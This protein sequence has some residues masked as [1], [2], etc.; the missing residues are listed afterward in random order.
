MR[1][2]A[3][4]KYVAKNWLRSS[5]KALRQL[6]DHVP[7][8]LQ[9]FSQVS[10]QLLV[11][12]T[13]DIQAK[14][15]TSETI[16][17]EAYQTYLGLQFHRYRPWHFCKFPSEIDCLSLISWGDPVEK[18]EPWQSKSPGTPDNTDTALCRQKSQKAKRE[19]DNVISGRPSLLQCFLGMLN[20][21]ENHFS[22]G[23]VK[24]NMAGWVPKFENWPL[25]VCY[26]FFDIH[27][28]SSSVV[29][30]QD[31]GTLKIVCQIRQKWNTDGWF[32]ECG[33]QE[34]GLSLSAQT[35]CFNIPRSTTT[36]NN[37]S[38]VLQ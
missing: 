21:F 37:W 5:N 18:E 31:K 35:Q 11:V 28:H 36:N 4:W 17:L 38:N 33:E 16:S 15:A 8:P 29:P 14:L 7:P 27:H 30:K 12:F 10:P 20:T 6:L 2:M 22:M 1:L 32:E 23:L 25:S 24:R 3:V 19:F 9:I 26:Q 13:M 34:P